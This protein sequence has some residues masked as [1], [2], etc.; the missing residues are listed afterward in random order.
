[1]K[2][3][4]ALLLLVA[5]HAEA[6]P[7]KSPPAK[8]P[9]AKTAEPTGPIHVEYRRLANMFEVMDNVVLWWKTKN[10][11]EYRAW[12]D[13]NASPTAEDEQYFKAY[14]EKRR[15]NFPKE[16]PP[17]E[18]FP[19]EKPVDWVARAFYESETIEEAAIALHGHVPTDDLA[20]F[21]KFYEHYEP[22]LVALHVLDES[23]AFV[24]I[25]K[26]MN[27]SLAG[28]GPYAQSVVEAYGQTQVPKF[29]ALY[30]WW[31]P[32][33][34]TTAN[35]RGDVLLLKYNPRCHA[36]DAASAGDIAVHEF[37]HVVSSRRAPAEREALAKAF[38]AGC[39]TDKMKPNY[40]LE[41]PLAVVIQ[42]RYQRATDPKHFDMTRPW[43]GGDK[44]VSPFAKAL[45]PIFDAHAH[46][47]EAFIRS[48]AKACQELQAR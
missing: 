21:R 13:A 1:M 15:E 6:P 18:I 35:Q 5:C 25:A 41:E 43:Y 24:D 17:P 2:L 28:V 38:R 14:I 39:A 8:S 27:A 31:P 19:S 36:D 33:E 47:D 20:F 42:K 32:V 22:R 11:P 10:D 29:T 46:V 23:L 34:N 37:A 26:A 45:F 16:Q 44:W 40:V 30:I 12:W 7:A 9:P 48:A 4:F 3:R